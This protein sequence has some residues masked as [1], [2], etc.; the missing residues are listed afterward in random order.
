MIPPLRSTSQTSAISERAYRY[1]R[2]SSP[3][4]RQQ[5]RWVVFGVA[6]AIVGFS[7]VI[8]LLNLLPGVQ[9]S[10]PL[11]RLFVVALIQG[12]MA[13]IPLAIGVAILRSRLYDID[14]IIN[15]TIVYGA[16]T[17]CVVGIYV[18]AVG[19]LGAIVP[20]RR[21]PA[22]HA[23]GDRHRG[24]DLRTPAR[25]SETVAS[26]PRRNTE[27]RRGNRLCYPSLTRT[28]GSGVSQHHP[29]RRESPSCLPT[30]GCSRISH[31]KPGSP[32]TPR[33]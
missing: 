7:T 15:R 9:R 10:G 24:G 23:G 30:G 22:G 31:V 26:R 3:W 28:R 12:S 13:L 33:A 20:G 5:T 16:L 27:H 11:T 1:R 25:C 32:P 21:E 19:Y 8:I 14:L 29:A 2:V 17:A 18:L 4:Q 6:V